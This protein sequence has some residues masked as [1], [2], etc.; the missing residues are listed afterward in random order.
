M[1]YPIL[2]GTVL[3]VDN[4]MILAKTLAFKCKRC[5]TILEV[6]QRDLGQITRPQDCEIIEGGCGRNFS[7]QWVSLD[8]F[9]EL[10]DCRMLTMKKKS[11]TYLVYDV[12]MSGEI[13]I[14][15][16]LEIKPQDC[17]LKKGTKSTFL[18]VPFSISM[19]PD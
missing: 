11:D 18:I 19:I 16:E 15:S 5:G 10:V 12:E 14:G 9:S 2:S 6:H 13:V 1:S 3:K 4:N 17:Q 7:D 8:R